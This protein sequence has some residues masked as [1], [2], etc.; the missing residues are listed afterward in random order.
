[1]TGRASDMT[2]K[3]ALV[4]GAAGGLG[5]ATALA[6]AKAGAQMC[7]VDHN[8]A[9]LGE[10][11]AMIGGT[12]FVYTADLSQPVNCKATVEAAVAN[13]GQLDALC[14]VAG[15]LKLANSHEMA[16]ADWNLVIA[17]NL[18]A[19]FL[20]S[21]AAIPWMAGCR[22]YYCRAV[23]TEQA[24]TTTALGSTVDGKTLRETPA[25]RACKHTEAGDT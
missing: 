14:N 18:T 8:A 9:G 19:P 6:L 12:E 7:I 2:G 21:Q 22:G 20:L 16:L 10:T 15:V 23:Q 13:F 4:T 24:K 5:R 11:A 3:V 17:V 1:M 25:K